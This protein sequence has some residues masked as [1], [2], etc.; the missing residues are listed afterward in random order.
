MV[1]LSVSASFNSPFLTISLSLSHCLSLFL[2]LPPQD[3]H[4]SQFGPFVDRNLRDGLQI[5]ARCVF[6]QYLRPE[7]VSCIQRKPLCSDAFTGW[8]LNSE[9]PETNSKE[10]RLATEH[11]YDV[12]IPAFAKK[13]M[14]QLA[15]M[16]DY[17][18]MGLHER[19]DLVG[20]SALHPKGL[21]IRHLVRF[22]LPLSLVTR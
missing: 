2:S 3:I 1:L 14:A 10:V 21:N 5:R 9:S 13:L 18:E 19:L 15:A 20:S 7:Y 17:L 11:V 4:D 8:D 6:Y 16:Q 22:C 12:L